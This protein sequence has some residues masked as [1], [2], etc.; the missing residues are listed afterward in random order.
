VEG[1]TKSYLCRPFLKPYCLTLK[2]NPVSELNSQNPAAAH[3][4]FNWSMDKRNATNYT[5]DQSAKL[6]ELYDSTF[7]TINNDEIVMGTIVGITKT[8]AVV[9][10]GFKS[11]GLVSLNEFR[12]MPSISVGEEIEVYVVN[13]EDKSG[14]LILSRKNAKLAK[15]WDKIVAAHQS[16]EIVTGVITS[17]TK[18]GLIVDV[19][20]LETFLPGSQIDV[21]PVTDYDAYVGLS[22]IHI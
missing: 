15:A 2:K 5:A 10:I 21:K 7:K 3:D 17:K 16:G 6:A 13:K 18:G 20:G 8:D 22:L 14:Q 4:D 19:F 12:D 11:D 1:G 9:N